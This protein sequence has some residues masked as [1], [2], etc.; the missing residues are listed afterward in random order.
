MADWKKIPSSTVGD[1]SKPAAQVFSEH[2][3]AFLSN[4]GREAIDPPSPGWLGRHAAS[5][6]VRRS[7][8]WN[9]NHV[10]ETHDPAILDLVEHYVDG[11]EVTR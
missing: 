10:D 7:G 11:T 3:I 5:E 1:V 4:Y 2:L 8:L 9:V 6:E